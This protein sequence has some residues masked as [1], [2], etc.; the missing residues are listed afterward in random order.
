MVLTG[1]TSHELFLT[2]HLA[3]SIPPSSYLITDWRNLVVDVQLF[4]AA[5]FSHSILVTRTVLAHHRR[6]GHDLTAHDD[7]QSKLTHS[8]CLSQLLFSSLRDKSL[9]TSFI[10]AAVTLILES[11][12]P[13]VSVMMSLKYLISLKQASEDACQRFDITGCT[14]LQCSCAYGMAFLKSFSSQQCCPKG[15]RS[16]L[17]VLPVAQQWLSP[18]DQEGNATLNHVSFLQF[19]LLVPSEMSTW[20]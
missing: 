15:L 10:H 11:T 19:P 20:M 8:N 3:T 14:V 7:A 2:H 9:L 17:P 1:H 12:L 6:T 13:L 16:L 4:S 5:C 18:S